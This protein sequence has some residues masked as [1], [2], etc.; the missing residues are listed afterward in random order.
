MYSICR[1]LPIVPAHI[2]KRFHVNEISDTR[3]ASC[4]RLLQSIWRQE[5]SFDPGR[6]RPLKGKTRKLGSRLALQF[7]RSGA[8]FLTPD[9]AKVVRKEAAYREIGALI[10]EHRLWENLL[11]SQALTFNLFARLKTDKKAAS[12]F[13][14]KLVPGIL[15]QVD[16]IVFEHSPG[17]GDPAFLGDYTAFDVFVEGTSAVG[18]PAFLAIEVKYAET[19]RQQQ[20]RTASPRYRELTLEYAL[21]RD[22]GDPGL[23]SEPLAQLT[24]E[25]LLAAVIRDRWDPKAIGAFITIAPEANREAWIA[26]ELYAR[27][28]NAATTPVPFT[29]LT[30]E[31]VIEMIRSAVDAD[32]ADGL[33][34]RYTDFGPVHAL[35]EDWVPYA[36]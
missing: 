11:S 30:L 21:H 24:G 12:R 33:T 31:A 19:L 15:K 22:P 16:R 29:A 34:E 28:V 25:H 35:I 13:F 4:A 26:I 3:F 20:R 5:R 27:T 18:A 8:N 1:P 2:L 7:A 6:Y 32:L 14:A 36:E 17:R 9:I 10:E 23:F